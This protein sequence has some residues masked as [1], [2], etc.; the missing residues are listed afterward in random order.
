[1]REPRQS[2]ANA[3][4]AGT[5]SF[6]RS[7]Q[8]RGLRRPPTGH[9]WDVNQDRF[10][11]CVV[12]VG[13]SVTYGGVAIGVGGWHLFAARW[14]VHSVLMVMFAAACLL[15]GSTRSPGRRRSAAPL[16]SSPEADAVPV[17]PVRRYPDQRGSE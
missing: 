14:S 2:L 6:S 15:S 1:M 7:P 17:G 16:V 4:R 11:T 10:L 9:W 8:L 3:G 5:F 12:F 13:T